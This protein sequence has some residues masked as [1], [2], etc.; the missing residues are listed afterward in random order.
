M[1]IIHK[2]LKKGEIKILVENKNDIWYLSTI[3][4]N[5]DSI[6]GKT[7]RKIKLGESADRNAKIVKKAIYIKILAEKIDYSPELLKVGGKI[8]EGP[9]DVARGSY[10]SFNIA[11]RTT[12]TI[13][14]ERW[15][16]Y[17]LDRIE[18]AC[19]EADS[20]IIMCVF[21]REEAYFAKLRKG[22]FDILS[23]IKG[24][25]AKKA[26]ESIKGS[27]FY[28]QI[29]TQLKEYAERYRSNH[30]IVASPSFWKD[31]LM[32][33]LKDESLRKKMIL[34]TC[35]SVDKTSF[36]EIMKR[37]EVK[38]ALKSE[39]FAREI[40]V[41]EDLLQGV[42]KGELAAYGIEEVKKA[43]D[44]GAAS[45]LMITDSLI[46]KSREEENYDVIEE[47]LKNVESMKGEVY[48]ISGE[49]E[50]GQKLDGIGGIG[51]LLRYRIG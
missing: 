50:G 9:E 37:D 8:T 2:D 27:N 18:E 1:R 7:I 6:S 41:V 4:D 43:V 13:T 10:H 25:V 49:H 34:A 3:I 39:R 30:I 19:E 11:E 5:G 20:P 36:N 17:Q 44:A 24:N 16:K 12:I 45:I 38:S 28:A 51:A 15:L 35:S 46:R 22:G 21:D 29:I 33:E 31:E 42:A 40:N 47:M 48:I 14:K 32:K 23:G 26:D